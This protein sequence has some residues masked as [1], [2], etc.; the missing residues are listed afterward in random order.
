MP[1]SR[2]T[3][4]AGSATQTAPGAASTPAGKATPLLSGTPGTTQAPPLIPGTPA[5]TGRAFEH[6]FIVMFEN[7]GAATVFANPYFKQL[8]ARGAYL[9]NYYAVGHPSEPNYLALL[10]GDTLVSDDG[11][12][13]L[14]QRNL[15][16]LLETAGI[17]WKAYQENYPGGCFA[18]SVAAGGLY[19]RKH[20]PFISFDTIR[21]NKARCAMI[22]PASELNADSA[23][24]RLPAYSFFTPNMDDDGHDQPL[25]F[26]AKWL[27]GFIEPKLKDPKFMQGTLVVVTFDESETSAD[28]HV[29]AALLGPMIQPGTVDSTRYSHYSLLRSVEENFHTGTLSRKDA[30]APPF[31]GCNFAGGCGK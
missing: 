30:Q 6:I 7:H 23:A 28:N 15:V 25:S 17:G 5:A 12:Y 2:A 31:A 18:G 1:S 4:P 27:E 24:G 26:A 10:A 16:D 3:S 21:S 13:N 22:A 20:N 14:P 9:S 19:A 11:V 29:Y 8:A